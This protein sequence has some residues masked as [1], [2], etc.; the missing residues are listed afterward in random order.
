MGLSDGNKLGVGVGTSD[1]K[2]D[3]E[4]E[5]ISV[6]R[7]HENVPASSIT[8]ESNIPSETS[9]VTILIKFHSGSGSA[10]AVIF[11]VNPSASTKGC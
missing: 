3:G 11:V 2:S 8:H 1:G 9:P 5:G 10:M 4:E 6:L 7:T